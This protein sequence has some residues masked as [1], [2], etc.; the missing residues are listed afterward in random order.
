MA[1]AEVE[2]RPAIVACIQQRKNDRKHLLD[3]KLNAVNSASPPRESDLCRDRQMCIICLQLWLRQPPAARMLKEELL[4]VHVW[5]DSWIFS[6]TMTML[7][8]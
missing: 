5:L 8:A 4:V 2:V 6:V 3:R 1:A 7:G